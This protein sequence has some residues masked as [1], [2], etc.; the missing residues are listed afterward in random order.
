MC[1]LTS[2]LLLV[3]IEALDSKHPA[4]THTTTDVE[5]SR[6]DEAADSPELD[7]SQRIANTL[8]PW[9]WILHSLAHL[10]QFG[11][12]MWISFVLLSLP[13]RSKSESEQDVLRAFGIIIGLKITLLATI[14]FLLYHVLCQVPRIFRLFGGGALTRLFKKPVLFWSTWVAILLWFHPLQGG[15]PRF[16]I[17]YAKLNGVWYRQTLVDHMTASLREYDA[18][19]LMLTVYILCVLMVTSLDHVYHFVVTRLGRRR[20]TEVTGGTELTEVNN[21]IEQTEDSIGV[22]HPE[23]HE[24]QG[25]LSTRRL[26]YALALFN[27]T[28]GT[29]YY[30][31]FFD[32][33]GT[34]SASW[35]KMLG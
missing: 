20:R 25:M 34:K 21:G 13:Y 19:A 6:V 29:L 12:W 33:T 4:E 11:V 8:R 28:Y 10:T 35:T 1:Y 3:V 18:C 24:E 14:G 22:E 17:R 15:S 16:T 2:F 5:F 27:L 23:E 26:S 7:P 9:S 31:L 32:G 30:V